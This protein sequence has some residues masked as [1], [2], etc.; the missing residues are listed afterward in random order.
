MGRKEVKELMKGNTIEETFKEY[1]GIM[2]TVAKKYK[3]RDMD[4]ED[5]LGELF[6]MFM[7]CYEKFD[8]KRGYQFSTFLQMC[9]DTELRRL[10]SVG[11]AQKRGGGKVVKSTVDVTKNEAKFMEWQRVAQQS[12]DWLCEGKMPDEEDGRFV[13]YSPFE[14]MLNESEHF[15]KWGLLDH[16]TKKPKVVSNMENEQEINL[17][18]AALSDDIDRTIFDGARQQLTLKE[19]QRT[20]R[21]NH[22]QSYSP[23]YISN[24]W[25]QV[26]LVTAK[27]IYERKSDDCLK[28]LG[29]CI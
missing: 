26:I 3:I 1:V 20:I 16:F 19:I 24:R 29:I 4:Y 21:K 7:K 25:N 6:I 14:Q 28:E 18:R 2:K 8:P 5:N 12:E 23:S 22:R 27:Q 15:L 10:H 13:N 17:I 9:C 11:F